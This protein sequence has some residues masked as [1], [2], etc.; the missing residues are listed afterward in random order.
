LNNVTQIATG[1]W[2]TCAL[3][4]GGTVAC[5]GWNY[6]GQLGFG[7]STRVDAPNPWPTTVAGLS[8]VTQIATGNSHTCALRN[9]GTV[10]CFGSNFH[11]ELGN[12][13]NTEVAVA[14]PTPTTVAGLSGVTQ[15]ATGGT[16]TCALRNDG[17]VA[18]FGSNYY[19]EL[20]TPSP[21]A[22]AATN[23]APITVAGLSGVTQ[24][25]AGDS[26]TCALR[27]D[28]TVAC[29]GR[30]TYGQLGN[31]SNNGTL[32]ANPTPTTVDGLTG[33]TAI[34]VG[35]SHTCAARNDGTV[36]CFGNNH[37]GQLGNTTNNG[38][39]TANPVPTA[40]AGL[41]TVTGIAAGFA[42]TCA[43]RSDGTVWCF[44][45]NAY[46]ELGNSTNSGTVTPNPT[47]TAAAGLSGVTQVAASFV[48]S[49]ALSGGTVACVGSN[50]YGELGVTTNSGTL[51]PN[52]FPTT[53]YW[54]G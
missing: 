50:R 19:G 35:T 24:I 28:G 10:A 29:F 39:D 53:V 45:S 49:C 46:G 6:T 23:P 40:V 27:N 9:D 5:F 15:I 3:R 17:T 1:Q 20:G 11:G 12:T 42:Q 22:T 41:S 33:V 16:H 38:T 52:P 4:T 37:Y 2:H 21:P 14:N 13:T 47:P 18:C 48:H 25:A 54:E 30:N 36:A 8:G 43:L 44:G 51:N 32:N 26:Q 34:A 31:T 7:T